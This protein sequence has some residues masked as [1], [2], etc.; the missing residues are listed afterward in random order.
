LLPDRPKSSLGKDQ[1]VAVVDAKTS[2]SGKVPDT[3]INFSSIR[4]HKE[5]N[6][7]DYV[8]VVGPSFAKGKAGNHAERDGVVLMELEPFL[9]ILELH[10]KTPL[11]LLTLREIFLRPGIYGTEPD[12]I[13]EA[14]SHLTRLSELLPLIIRKIERWY[15]LNHN[16]PVTAD[17]LFIAFIEEFGVTRYSKD[18]IESALK[19]LASPFVGALRKNDTGYYL[20]MP[21]ETVQRRLFSLSQQFKVLTQTAD[22]G[23]KTKPGKEYLGG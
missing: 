16:S 17:A 5:K 2:R 20:T 15:T 21:S 23:Q 22:M 10:N 7:A 12:R 3:A 4:D 13:K 6:R 14:S 1:Y 8:M 19:H 9:A 11:S 18:I